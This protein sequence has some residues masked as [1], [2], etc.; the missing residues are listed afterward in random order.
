[1]TEKPVSAIRKPRRGRTPIAREVSRHKRIVTFV[2]DADSVK[3]ERLAEKK[4]MS[5][6]AVVY[7]IL[8]NHLNQ[9]RE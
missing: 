3:L 1:M 9:Q 5:L 6:S 4:N 8:S 2:T 7:E